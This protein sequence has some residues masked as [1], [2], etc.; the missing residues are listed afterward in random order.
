TDGGLS[1]SKTGHFILT[2]VKVQ[3]R[4][5]DRSQVREIVVASAIA[6]YSADPK[7]HSGYGNVKDTLD[8]DPRNGWATFDSDPRQ[9]HSAVFALAEPLVLAKEEELILE[10]RQRSTQ[11]EHNIGRFRLSLTDQPGAVVQSLDPAPLEQLAAA[12]VTDLARV[13]PKLRTRLFD[14]FLAD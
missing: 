1:R 7:K 4:R 12:P 2:D 11:G 13:D 8:D 3:V 6:D 10:L 5:R 9:P 14:Q